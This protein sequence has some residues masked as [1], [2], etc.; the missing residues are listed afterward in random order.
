MSDQQDLYTSGAAIEWRDGH[1]KR[2]N[3]R[4][5][6]HAGTVHD[7]HVARALSVRDEFHDP[8][9]WE[10]PELAPGQSKNLEENRRILKM[11][12][13]E[14]FTG[15]FEAGDMSTLKHFFGDPD[16]RADISGIKSMERFKSLILSGPAP[17][18]YI[19]APPGAGKTNLGAFLSQLWKNDQPSD[20]L[21]GSNIK[22]LEET[23]EWV[24]EEGRVRDGWLA[25]YGEVDEWL[26]QDGDVLAGNPVPKL[27]LWDEVSSAGSGVGEQGYTMRTK[28][29][30]LLFKIRKYG[31]CII[32][33]GHDPKS[34]APLVREMATIIHKE[35]LKTATIYESINSSGKP[36]GQIG[37]PIEGI[38]ATDYRYNDKEP[39]SWSW[40]DS[41]TDEGIEQDVLE[42]VAMWT[43]VQGR[44]R[45]DPVAWRDLAK[46]TPWDYSTCNRRYKRYQE[47]GKYAEDVQRVSHAIA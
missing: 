25:S 36:V 33:I 17:I 39:T 15:A 28:M 24:D 10:H 22:T 34:V 23:D 14:T 1:L 13:T 3:D 5:H 7:E 32:I 37:K 27:F 26:K 30:P 16:Q 9:R 12:G 2:E 42:A 31:G 43:I 18:I 11:E 40:S 47:D 4:A 41:R 21:L 35:D 45:D 38:P 6:Y 20:A 8:D 19:Y 46:S 44:E 29:G